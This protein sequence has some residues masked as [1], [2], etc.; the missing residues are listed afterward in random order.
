M[1][2]LFSTIKRAV[3]EEGFLVGAHAQERMRER[4]VLLGHVVSGL[5]DGVRMLED[6]ARWPNP[7]VEVEQ[8]L[9]D[10]TPDKAVWSFLR[11]DDAAK[12]VTVHFFDGRS[13][14]R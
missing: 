12:L 5:A 2:D 7:V 6:A 4:R 3:A 9:P 1:D 8:L 14:P 10:G 13:N 11:D